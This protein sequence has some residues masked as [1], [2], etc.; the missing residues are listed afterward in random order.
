MGE[1]IFD[2]IQVIFLITTLAFVWTKEPC[3]HIQLWDAR[4]QF[5]C[6]D[7]SWYHCLETQA[8]EIKEKC[9]KPKSIRSGHYPVFLIGETEIIER[10][11]PP[12][13]YQPNELMSNQFKSVTCMYEK[14]ECND[15]GEEACDDG[16]DV[17]DRMCRCDFRK[18]YGA[19][20]YLLNNPHQKSCY[21]PTSNERG[22]VM[23]PCGKGKELNKV[24]QCVPVCPSGYYRS[25]YDFNCVPGRSIPSSTTE[26]P[27][28][29]L[30]IDKKIEEPAMI[31]QEGDDKTASIV[32]IAV[33]TTIALMI[34]IFLGLYCFWRRKFDGGDGGENLH[35][36][37]VDSL[38]Y[39]EIDIIHGH[40][41][42]ESIGCITVEPQ[43]GRKGNGTGFRVGEKYVMTAYHVV[44]DVFEKFWK[45]VHKRLKNGNNEC[46]KLS[47]ILESQGCMPK[48]GKWSLTEILMSLDPDTQKKLKAVGIDMVTHSC[49][50][51]FGCVGEKRGD[52]FTFSYD[53]LFISKQ[54]DVAI[55]E[56]T[57]KT[58]QPYPAKL[59]FVNFNLPMDR[60]HVLGHPN[61]GELIFDPSCSIISDQ[62]K[63][64][65]TKDEAITLFTSHGKTKS[66]VEKE[67]KECK[68]SPNHIL[69]HCSKS[70]AHGAS[71]S[72]LLQIAKSTRK[73]VIIGMLL[74]G[75][76][77]MYYNE[78]RNNEKVNKRPELLIES[79]I[80]VE[81]LK[82]LFKQHELSYLVNDIFNELN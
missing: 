54:H 24:Y 60:L 48:D 68:L 75:Y 28:Q 46:K 19:L 47:E 40:N 35:K 1:K 25:H 3:P 7:P 66:Q 6:E 4:A 16:S 49:R 81:T 27:R 53:A 39:S 51:T 76:P 79:G 18:G 70:T 45:E 62:E 38:P 44:Q 17:S 67:Y 32:A 57:N 26:S 72:P 55:L 61:G 34:F 59:N 22:C 80:A 29:I 15:D 10:R 14:D 71:G 82:T 8:G 30:T 50:I 9:V 2:S 43:A 69:F 64:K 74:K 23:I 11:C 73:P 52:T 65:E 13:L 42:E 36:P 37:I 56:L 20:E 58:G 21:L 63:L 31:D 12:T 33:T 77:K 41:I 78:F 5:L